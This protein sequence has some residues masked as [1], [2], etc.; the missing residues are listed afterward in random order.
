[1][2]KFVM[3]M[4]LLG[5][6]SGAEA[7]AFKVIVHESMRVQSLPKKTVS[8]FLLKK[9]TKWPDDT[10]VVPVDQV[11]AAAVRDP[12]SRAIHGKPTSAIKSYWTQQIFSGRDVPP[13]EK[14]SDA[15]VVAFVRA[16]P[17][18]IGYVSE[19]A[20]ADGVRVLTVN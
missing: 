6:S 10:P 19:G 7:A 16:N 17:G 12:F 9:V 8:D 13:V 2:K 14:K 3:I 4:L 5:L 20:A 1:M 11:E 15:E 18:A